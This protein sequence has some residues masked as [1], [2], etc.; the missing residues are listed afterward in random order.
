MEHDSPKAREEV[1]N[2]PAL[3]FQYCKHIQDLEEVWRKLAGTPWA[4]HYCK[5]VV[6]RKELWS[7]LTKDEH[8]YRYCWTVMDRPEVVN[9]ITSL[10]FLVRYFDNVDPKRT[11][12]YDKI[13]ALGGFPVGHRLHGVNIE[14]SHD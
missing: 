12:C 7:S 11:E 9:K 10:D 5:E 6:D 1:L 4:V 14:V 8:L 2:S 3:C 13:M